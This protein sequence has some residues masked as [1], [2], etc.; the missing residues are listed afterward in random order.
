[1][2][3]VDYLGK[4]RREMTPD[5][6]KMSS[7]SLPRTQNEAPPMWSTDEDDSYQLEWDW[8]A[9]DLSKG[10]VWYDDR[11][12]KLKESTRHLENPEYWYQEGIEC[13]NRHRLNYTEKGPQS[14]QILW[15]EFPK[16]HWKALREGCRLGFLITPGGELA[17]NGHFTK[18]E[19]E[20]AGTFVDELKELGVLIPATEELKAN[21][22]LFCVNKSYDSRQKRC[23]VNCKGGGQ[24][25]CMG[26]DPVY[27]VQKETMLWRM[28]SGGWTGIADAS[29]QFHNFLTDP[30]VRKCL[31]CIHPVTDEQ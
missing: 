18:E 9:Q 5:T 10:S 7:P 15:W 3:V 20:V 29:K 8:E 21:C 6:H 22:P 26:K 24:N 31:G 12:R 11:I 4:W 23:I 27:L 19:R 30:E 28:Y 16:A 13:L 25:M 1:M 2:A 14:L 17:L